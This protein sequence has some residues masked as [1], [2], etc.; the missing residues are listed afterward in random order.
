MSSQGRRCRLEGAR[1]GVGPHLAAPT[2]LDGE[3]RRADLRFA[4]VERVAAPR[5]PG[6]VPGRP[7]VLVE[8][9]ERAVLGVHA[10]ARLERHEPPQAD[11]ADAVVAGA[12]SRTIGIQLPWAA[13]CCNTDSCRS[14]ASSL[15][16][17]RTRRTSRRS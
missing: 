11:R 7:A 6:A 5:V 15:C 17:K 14:V 4:T 8:A 12:A 3:G 16:R 10:A 13:A 9:V 1:V 2:A